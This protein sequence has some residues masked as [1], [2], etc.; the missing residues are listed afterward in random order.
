MKKVKRRT[1]AALLIAI[2]LFFGLGVYFIRY[3]AHGSDWATF[4]SNSSVYQ[5]GIL[6]VGTVLDRNG[7]VLSTVEDGSRIYSDNK[8]VRMATLHAVGDSS[9][10]IGTGACPLCCAA[11]RV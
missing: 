4:V 3:M 8:S 6:K 9:G 7:I 11:N 5:N 2:L 1:T 10:N